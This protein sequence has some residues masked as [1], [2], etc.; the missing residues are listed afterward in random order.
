MVIVLISAFIEKRKLWTFGWSI[1]GVLRNSLD[2][3][4]GHF[5][6]R[7]VASTAGS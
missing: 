1:N 6:D 7:L 2:L 3:R 5:H 4:F